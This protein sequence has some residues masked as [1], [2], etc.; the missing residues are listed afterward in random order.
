MNHSNLG[1]GSCAGSCQL[2]GSAPLD[3]PP[4]GPRLAF[5]PVFAAGEACTGFGAVGA[6]L[7]LLPPPPSRAL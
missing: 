6:Q 3:T 5:G 1:A 4:G 7:A 2:R